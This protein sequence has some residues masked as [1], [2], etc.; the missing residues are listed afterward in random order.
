MGYFASEFLS[1]EKG[2]NSMIVG[3]DISKAPI[4]HA[5]ARQ[6]KLT[7]GYI[8]N[9]ASSI[10]LTKNNFDLVIVVA[11]LHHLSNQEAFIRLIEEVERVSNDNASVLFVENTTDNP[12][13]NYLVK[14]WRKIGSS[15][16]HLHG[17]KSNERTYL[18][19]IRLKLRNR[20]E[21]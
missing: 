17:F 4:F 7:R 9:D 20:F 3:F 21:T 16:L 19:P 10:P 12:L 11:V 13:K 2:F 14:S 6:G 1:T 18:V 8:V 5:K 15:D